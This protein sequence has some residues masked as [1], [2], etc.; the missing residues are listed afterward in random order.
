M[1]P[2]TGA[3]DITGTHG[4]ATHGTVHGIARGTVHGIGTT[5]GIGDALITDGLGI[6]THG[7]TILGTIIHGTTATADG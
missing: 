5:L 4:I 3:Q 6:T 2:G 1:H 7:I